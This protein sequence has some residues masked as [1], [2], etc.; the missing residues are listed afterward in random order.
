[1]TATAKLIVTRPSLNDRFYFEEYTGG[2]T[3]GEQQL[4]DLY[5]FYG[6][7]FITG[8]YEEL[9]SYNEIESRVNELRPDLLNVFFLP[10]EEWYDAFQP[11]VGTDVNLIPV[12]NWGFHHQPP[13]NP[14]ALTYTYI[15]TYDNIENLQVFLSSSVLP[16]LETLKSTAAEFNNTI[17]VYV[18]GVEV[19]TSQ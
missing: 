9:I 2:E 6:T 19:G 1:M 5:N 13:F 7:G 15:V 4:Q 8:T 10:R 18:D 12:H 14:F 17:K 11:V 16:D 3:P